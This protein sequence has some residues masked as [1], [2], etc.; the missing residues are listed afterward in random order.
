MNAR[1]LSYSLLL[2][3]LVAPYLCGCLITG[4]RAKPIT[5]DAGG[6]LTVPPTVPIVGTTTRQEVEQRYRNFRVD[7]G[8]PTLY[9]ARVNSSDSRIFFDGIPNDRIWNSYNMV[10]TFNPNQVVRSVDT[11]SDQTLM[12]EVASM[13]KQGQLPSLDFAAPVNMDAERYPLTA[14]ERSLGSE[15]L[16]VKVVLAPSNLTISATIP[17]RWIPRRSARSAT[18]VIPREQV[19]SMNMGSDQEEWHPSDRT[20]QV[21][22]RSKPKTELGSV[23]AFKTTFTDALTLARWMAQTSPTHPAETTR[24]SVQ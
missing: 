7:P 22:V 10:V 18:V 1:G 6:R 9:W 11:F 14:D 15:Q 8:V 20:I 17:G 4:A 19:Q 16:S 5:R 12:N 21:F 24:P 2:S 3:F 23:I 13:I